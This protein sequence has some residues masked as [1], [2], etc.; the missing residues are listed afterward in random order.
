MIARRFTEDAEPVRK[1]R[2]SV[3]E[4][5]DH[6]LQRALARTAADRFPTARGFADALAIPTVT[7]GAIAQTV[8]TVTTAPK[9]LRRPVLI[10]LVAGLLIGGGFLFAWSSRGGDERAATADSESARAIRIAV[11]PF[12]NLGDTADAYF[13]D[14]VTDAVRGKLAGIDGFAVIARGSSEEYRGSVKSPT[15]IADELDVDYLLTGTVRWVKQA[16]GTSRVQVRPELVEIGDGTAQTRW[17]EPFNAPL[18]DV[19]EV[20]EQIAGQVSGALNV[21]LGTPE[22]QRLAERPTANIEA[23]NLFLR[24]EEAV[25]A[26]DPASVRRAVSLY[27]LAV[28]R[29][30]SFGIAWARLAANR[31]FLRAISPNGP[32]REQV[33]DAL[34][35]AMALAPDAPET[36]RARYGYADLVEGDRPGAVAVAEEGLRRYPNETNLLRNLGLSKVILGD[37]AAGAGLLQRAVALDPRN[38]GPARGLGQ[39]KMLMGRFE[40]ARE[41]LGRVVELVPNDHAAVLLLMLTWL[42]QGDLAGA[43]RLINSM[44][45]PDGRPGLLAHTA[46][47]GDYYW[48]LDAAQQD[49]V[50]GLGVDAFD[51]DAGSRALVSAQVLH[52]RG[53]TAGARRFAEIAQREFERASV[54][55]QD[56]QLPALA[57]FAV[58]LQGR[59]AEARSRLARALAATSEADADIQSY[60]FELT[61]RAAM[62]AGDRDA[63]IA[64]LERFVAVGVPTVRGRIKVHPEFAPLRVNPR[65]QRIVR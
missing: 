54:S 12:V 2:P 17:D 49:T 39:A 24:A 30:S 52:S 21:A 3:A 10:A 31:A 14:G 44:H 8:T 27:E 43:R 7:T 55:S 29:D 4:S 50:M 26:N 25:L 16:D 59:S 1:H 35:R 63:A 65:F 38:P 28:A 13:A 5:I 11:I 45:P 32:S 22:Q 6:A 47:Y 18:T 51:G 40:E 33:R 23:Y 48:L 61:A 62:L 53:D 42:G 60:N 46:M 19:F 56:P 64:A 36:Y 9:S 58:A 57:G 41:P 37:A 34:D 15:Q 20:Q